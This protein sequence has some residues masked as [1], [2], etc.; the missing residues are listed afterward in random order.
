MQASSRAS[1]DAVPHVKHCL[2]LAHFLSITFFNEELCLFIWLNYISISHNLNH[3][4]LINPSCSSVFFNSSFLFYFFIFY[5]TIFL[6]EF[7]PEVRPPLLLT[8]KWSSLHSGHSHVFSVAGPEMDLL[9]F[10]SAAV[11][12]R[13]CFGTG[14]G[15][16][17]YTKQLNSP[18]FSSDNQNVTTP[19]S[20]VRTQCLPEEFATTITAAAAAT[21]SA[22]RR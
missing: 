4:C 13:W 15:G 16:S 20:Q 22:E 2:S 6:L 3:H 14:S 5:L 8:Q 7:E 10:S 12:R 17:L 1:L 19:V 21:S 18:S 9:V 11:P